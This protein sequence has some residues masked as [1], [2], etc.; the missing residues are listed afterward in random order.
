MN[1]K[2]AKQLRKLASKLA[3]PEQK[4]QTYRAL[5]KEARRRGIG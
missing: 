5:K 2:K 3:A 1:S 4:R